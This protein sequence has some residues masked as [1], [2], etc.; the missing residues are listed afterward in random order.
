MLVMA[1]RL[2]KNAGHRNCIHLRTAAVFRGARSGTNRSK[3]SPKHAWNRWTDDV[4][5]AGLRHS[6]APQIKTLPGTKQVSI[7]ERK[8]K[9]K[10]FRDIFRGDFSHGRMK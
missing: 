5:A 7:Q 3:V 9:N 6:R 2:A 8:I 4:A 1:C 10:I